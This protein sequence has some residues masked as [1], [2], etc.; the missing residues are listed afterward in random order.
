HGADLV[1]YERIHTSPHLRF[2]GGDLLAKNRAQPRRDRLIE[3]RAHGEV[4]TVQR[5]RQPGLYLEV[6]DARDRAPDQITDRAVRESGIARPAHV[7]GPNHEA[8]V[9]RVTIEIEAELRRGGAGIEPQWHARNLECREPDPPH[10]R[11]RG[12]DGDAVQMVEQQPGTEFG[13]RRRCY[14]RP[15]VERRIAGQTRQPARVA[16]GL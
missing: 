11:P 7:A 15:T 8:R 9:D 2:G 6:R 1:L 10:R 14:S 4:R 16:L 12:I 3:I 5:A 13:T